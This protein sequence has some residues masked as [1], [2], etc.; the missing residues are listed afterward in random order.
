MSAD[1][2]R[3]AWTLE[4]KLIY[5]MLVAG[6]SADFAETV[7]NRLYGDRL[8]SPFGWFRHVRS[9]GALGG[10]LRKA[11][12]GNYTKLERGISE[13]IDEKHLYLE[14]VTPERLEKIHGI[15]P[16]TSRFFI[17]WTRAN[18]EYAALDT[19]VLKWL[20]FIGHAAPSSTPPKGAPYTKW[21]N[22]FISEA[23]KRGMRPRELDA[24]IWDY[25]SK[26]LHRTGTWPAN[27]QP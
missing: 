18:A 17:L 13:L 26:G 1:E 19:H 24:R 4:Y 3:R 21:E 7:S 16:K 8:L 23:H 10:E 27:L 20:R 22:L 14:T 6:K 2:N 9:Q 25:C 5:S 11:R 15:G 12:S